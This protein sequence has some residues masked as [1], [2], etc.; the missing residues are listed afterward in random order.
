MSKVF[1]V[2]RRHAIAFVTLFLLLSGSAYAVAGQV[3][4]RT[5]P[6]QFYACVAGDFHTLN[7]TK[8]GRKCPGG[9]TK[10]SWNAVGR[11]GVAGPK[12]QTGRTG[13]RGAA[14]EAG[15]SGTNGAAGPK[16]DVGRAGAA[17]S[18]GPPGSEGDTGHAGPVGAAGAKGDTGHAGPVGAAGAKGDTGHAGPV[19]PA[20]AKGDTGH[21]G[22]V[23]AAGAKGD[24]GHAGPVGPAGAK[25]DT[26]HAGPVG[27][28][29]AK[30]D[31]GHAGPVGPVGA[32]GDTGHAGPVGP[33]GAKGDT[34]A[35]G[36][37]VTTSYGF[38]ADSSATRA[39]NI[40]RPGHPVPFSGFNGRG[41]TANRSN[42]TFTVSQSGLY[43][44]DFLG[45]SRTEVFYAIEV[46]GVALQ[47]QVEAKPGQVL[48]QQLPSLRAGDVLRV[49][50]ESRVG[51]MSH[52]T[53]RILRVGS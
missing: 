2:L 19:G 35:A 20:G 50:S 38:A 33:A 11:R 43:E 1:A 9:Q 46:N 21:A 37:P 44:L 41:V 24:T 22:P 32:K 42:T 36:P 40:I 23:G 49:V 3:G 17:G 5:K 31:T 27:A 12:G 48:V 7:L 52:A 39:P 34:G 18:Q 25:G 45:S 30:G 13:A 51:V 28:A 4:T 47:P 8:A 14:G 15:A 26:G 10:I 6:K 29:G 53:L 16:G